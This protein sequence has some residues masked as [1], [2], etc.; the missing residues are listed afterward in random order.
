M[1]E[2]TKMSETNKSQISAIA[3]WNDS[4]IDIGGICRWKSNDHVPFDDMLQSFVDAS[5][6][7]EI[8][9]EDS[10]IVRIADDQKFFAEYRESQANRTSEQIAE[11]RFE[12]RAAM[13]AGVE[14]INV[15]SGE[16]W[17]T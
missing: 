7:A 10:T 11:E 14:M 13:G 4:Y 17:T 12:A 9:M 5:L 15:I 8:V 3:D 2:S 6:L 16:K 1:K